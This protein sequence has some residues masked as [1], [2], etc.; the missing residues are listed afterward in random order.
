MEIIGNIADYND[1]AYISR[2]ISIVPDY[3][4]TVK[5]V[6]YT[7]DLPKGVN[8]HHNLRSVWFNG[9]TDLV[10][11]FDDYIG[12]YVSPAFKIEPDMWKD[13]NEPLEKL[14]YEE[15]SKQIMH[16]TGKSYREK[17]IRGYHKDTGRGRPFW[18]EVTV[19]Y[20]IREEFDSG[21]SGGFGSGPSR[22]P[23][24]IEATAKEKFW[25]QALPNYSPA[26]FCRLYF[27]EHGGYLRNGK[28]T[29]DYSVWKKDMIDGGFK[30]LTM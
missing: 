26:Y 2:S 15:F 5:K 27:R 8:V 16:Y 4:E 23:I 6:E 3:N 30:F 13:L 19:T 9:Q 28:H 20:E 11:D 10:D 12:H 22:P 25:F 14:T 21:D 1:G 18:I 7:Y 17:G 29:R 24:I